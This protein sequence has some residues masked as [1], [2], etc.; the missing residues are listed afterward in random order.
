M[1]KCNKCD[2]ELKEGMKFCFKC[3]TKVVT[4]P[5]KCSGCGAKI[6]KDMKFCY[7]C[8]AKVGDTTKEPQKKKEI[9]SKTSKI[10]SKALKS[11]NRK[12]E[13]S[14]EHSSE[15]EKT[16]KATQK[17]VKA[18]KKEKEEL[19]EDATLWEKISH[20]ISNFLEEDDDEDSEEN[21]DDEDDESEED[22][23]SDIDFSALMSNK[24]L[25][26]IAILLVVLIIAGLFYLFSGTSDIRTQT[27][28]FEAIPV[29]KYNPVTKN[30]QLTIEDRTFVRS[31][32]I[33][34]DHAD[35]MHNIEKG[36]ELPNIEKMEG[37]FGDVENPVNV[38]VKDEM[39]NYEDQP[40]D[41]EIHTSLPL[42]KEENGPWV[43]DIFKL[44]PLE[45]ARFVIL[46]N[47]VEE[48]PYGSMNG[49]SL[50]YSEDI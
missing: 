42:N 26:V 13:E 24:Y 40:Y 2:S 32:Q 50:V 37:V 46:W 9:G 29:L 44:Y 6:K 22:K 39:P 15:E 35:L 16:E 34:G 1:A 19:P 27:P 33:Y 28:V 18:E 47:D 48:F 21:D 12:F 25:L 31:N 7:E 23:E 30:A 38:L 10:E 5:D 11:T 8:G 3:G 17:K 49:I 36:I 20:G 45:D 4:I 14:T 41:V 43:S